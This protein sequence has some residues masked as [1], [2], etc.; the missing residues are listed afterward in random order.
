MFSKYGYSNS[1]GMH[2]KLNFNKNS[3]ILEITSE[4]K[5]LNVEN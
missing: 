2:C 3:I 1:K 4:E 5:I